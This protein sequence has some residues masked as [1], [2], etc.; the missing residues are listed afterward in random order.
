MRRFVS[1]LGVLSLVVTGFMLAP[2]PA[3]A[4]SDY[5]DLLQVSDTLYVYTDGASKS[6][7]MDISETWW[8]DFKQTYALRLA[9]GIGWPANFIT[10]FEA[11]MATGS[12]GI[13]MQENAYGITID[14][15]GTR[16]PNATCGF[17]GS[18][19][20]PYY[21]CWVSEG[22][23]Y[24]SVAAF[25][26]SSYGN[27]GCWG[28]YGYRC[29]DNGMNVY[30]A[31]YVVTPEQAT[32]GYWL[33]VTSP[34]TDSRY[35]MSNFNNTYPT[36]YEGA[37]LPK[38]DTLNYV[39][40]GDSFSSGEGVEPFISGTDEDSPNEN[41]CH[42]S[43]NA[44][45][46]LLAADTTQKT[47]LNLTNFVACSGATTDTLLNNRSGTGAWN[48]GAQ[49]NALSE[50]TDIV[51]VSIGG[52]DVGFSDYILACILATCGPITN[53]VV[54]DAMMDGIEAPA[55]KVNLMTAYEAILEEAPNAI[56]VYVVD[57]PYMTTA[58][59]TTCNAVDMTGAFL[60]TTTINS[61][62]H[63]AVSD[64]ALTDSRLVLVDTNAGASPFIGGEICG[65]D[66]HF[67]A[68]VLIPA[69]NQPFSYHPNNKG[70]LAYYNILK[71]E[72]L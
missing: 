32:G 40:M 41:R 56:A 1:I 47:R 6:Q 27:N 69:E 2:A 14:I 48:E 63:D 68:E 15:A 42:R 16:D 51:T 58:L 7:T 71:G 36:G 19:E 23:G 38:Q 64:V 12:W 28:S 4:V 9:Q 33:L 43:E 60:V 52:N 10:E 65:M 31:P 66:P 3:Q 17:G 67:N 72:M 53:P 24:V 11:I 50:S 37:I 30:N 5:D 8:H 13:V 57:Y 70:Q 49:V 34:S 44:Y 62:I 21:G 35:Y 59:Q 54:Y 45:P 29:S 61:V 25:T 18:I 39:A 55:F 46:R 26:H 20:A 22:Y